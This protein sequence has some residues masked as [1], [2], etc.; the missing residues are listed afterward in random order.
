MHPL[1]AILAGLIT[2][3][4]LDTGMIM[5]HVDVWPGIIPEIFEGYLG[6]AILPPV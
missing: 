4:L 6:G 5:A 2:T 1:P 3:A